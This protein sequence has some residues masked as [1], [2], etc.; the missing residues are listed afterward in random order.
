MDDCHF[1][2]KQKILSPPP[3][4]NTMIKSSNISPKFQCF[5]YWRIFFAKIGP[6]NNDFDQCKGFFM[7]KMVQIGQI[8]KIKKKIQIARFLQ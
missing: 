2:Y 8:S 3:K 4:K 6:E 7:G 5:F 1:G